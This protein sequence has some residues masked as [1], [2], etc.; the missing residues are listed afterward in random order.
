MQAATAEPSSPTIPGMGPSKGEGRRRRAR[1]AQG[2]DRAPAR[3]R[4]RA[5]READGRR[6]LAG[7]TFCFTGALS[8]PRKELEQ[9]VEEHGGT[10][11]S[12]VTKELNYL[13][14]ADPSSG[15]SKAQKA[16]KYGTECIDEA[17]FFALIKTTGKVS[18]SAAKPKSKNAGA[19]A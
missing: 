12:G 10:L 1:G 16:R 8:R 14:M 13:V 7:K 18:K 15:S 3:G 6:P 5:G 2:R 19:T 9:L 11:L 17:G 4:R